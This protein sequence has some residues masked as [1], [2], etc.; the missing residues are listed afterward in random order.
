MTLEDDFLFIIEANDDDTEISL[1]IISS[2]GRKIT[3]N[4]FIVQLEGY[5]HDVTTA[6]RQRKDSGALDH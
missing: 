3:Q 2:S 4:E 1:R 6:E 5:L